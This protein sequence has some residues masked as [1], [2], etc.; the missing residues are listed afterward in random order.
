MKLC[1]Q[2]TRFIVKSWVSKIGSTPHN[3]ILGARL[4]GALLGTRAERKR[5]LGRLASINSPGPEVI[6]I[7]NIIHM[8]L[9]TR[10]APKGQTVQNMSGV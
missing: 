1:L 7:T 4:P 5:A 8:V 3:L 2:I 10:T 9:S 6:H